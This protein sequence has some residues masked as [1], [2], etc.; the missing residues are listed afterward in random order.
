MPAHSCRRSGYP[1]FAVR[2][3]R[4]DFPGKIKR[5]AASF[6]SN[7]EPRGSEER[8]TLLNLLKESRDLDVHA[9]IYHLL[10]LRSRASIL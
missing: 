3:G 1:S 9:T 2:L 6:S 8:Q 5:R 7:F 10:R 4:G